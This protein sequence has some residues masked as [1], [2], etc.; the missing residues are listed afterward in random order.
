VRKVL[1]LIAL[2]CGFASVSR[3]QLPLPTS[4]SGVVQAPI[5]SNG[6]KN[7]QVTLSQNVTAFQFT[8]VPTPAQAQ[9]S[10]IFTQNATGGFT[11]AYASYTSNGTTINISN[12]CTPTAT[13]N[14][15]TVCQ[16]VFNAATS[17]WIGISGSSS[18]QNALGFPGPNPQMAAYTFYVNS[19]TV[20][21]RNNQTGAIDYS[22]ADARLV[23]QNA[24][25]NVPCSTYFFK[26]GAYPISTVTLESSAT[27]IKL[28]GS[29]YY[30]I[31]IPANAGSANQ[32]CQFRFIGESAPYTDGFASQTSGVMFQATA[33]ARTA[34]GA[35][36]MIAYFWARPDT[37]NN[38]GN[39]V[40][41]ENIGFIGVDNQRGSECAF[42]F[43]EAGTV[44]YINVAA[45]MAPGWGNP[46]APTISAPVAGANG[47]IAF[48]TTK[49][50]HNNWQVFDKTWAE[51]AYIGYDVESEHST[52]F[53][54]SAL[55]CN[56]AAEMGRITQ[57]SVPTQILHPGSWNKFT[58]QENINGITLGPNM[59]AGG[60]FNI[61]SY[62]VEQLT[63]TA[64][65]RVNNLTET[66]V[67]YTSGLITYRVVNAGVGATNNPSLWSA[68]GTGFKMMQGNSPNTLWSAPAFDNFAGGNASTLNPG[69]VSC[70]VSACGFP[71]N[72]LTVSSATATPTAGSA[73][74]VASQFAGQV[75]NN[76]QFSQAKVTAINA[77]DAVGVFV[78][79]PAGFT[80]RTGYKYAASTSGG[81]IPNRAIYK[82]VNNVATLLVQTAAASGVAVNDVM[83][84]EAIGTTLNAYYCPAGVC[85]GTPD[86]TTTDSAITSGYPGITVASNVTG[87]TSLG[88]WVGG[89]LPTK[90]GTD[91]IY[92]NA[93]FAPTYNT[94]TNCAS[95]ASPA[96]C[97]SAAGGSV[98][99]PT[100]TT[101]STLQVNS[102]AVTANSQ[103]LFYPDDS[104]GT[105][106]GVTCNSTL[107]TLAGGSFISARVSG[108]S[109]TITFNGSILT[110]GVCGSFLIF[111]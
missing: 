25:T 59:A 69:W 106:L 31:A 62:D 68:G 87:R 88:N 41:V 55:L 43:Y 97:G 81:L 34:A 27:L 40:F 28:S 24:I 85:P 49:S 53:S 26:V 80:L 38:V 109:F 4:P 52:V 93:E 58:D 3:A 50:S 8:G 91:S 56:T 99:I 101:S 73:S 83:K 37:T 39:D 65:A 75:F 15:T 103:I 61:F 36:N 67:G 102:T 16:F 1:L 11:V 30:G 19:G 82:I 111:N 105:R 42:C 76:D 23:V 22:G 9:V 63:T 92:A 110:N 5:D 60:E 10:V 6:W 74:D 13:A 71:A 47:L 54:A 95:S 32:Y 21:A 29:L 104:L 35:G 108:T 96:V 18:A 12:G 90:N 66:N 14:A 44:S 2:V 79:T 33:A 98:V 107:A 57:G 20:Y 77:A 45:L 89:S 84:L 86:L 51:G 7:F 46:T 48:T 70:Q 94:L 100:G 72:V 17:T 64:F 78:R